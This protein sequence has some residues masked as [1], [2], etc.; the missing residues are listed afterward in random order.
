MG[1]LP[2]ESFEPNGKPGNMP[3]P[4]A[5]S[6]VLKR[7]AAT[8]TNDIT[9]GDVQSA[10]ADRSFA[11]LVMFFALVNMLPLPIGTSLILGV[12][13]LLLSVQMVMGRSAPWLPRFVRERSIAPETFRRMESRLNPWIEWMEKFIKPRK[14]PFDRIMGERVLGV[15]IVFLAILLIIPIPMGNWPPAFAIFLVALALWERDGYML[16]VALAASVTATVLFTISATVIV[17][18]SKGAAAYIPFL[19]G[20]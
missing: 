19:H 17:M 4:H 6:D 12:P 16:V 11:A 2:F 14:W 15:L 13:L 7:L 18:V 1:Q 10:L 9:I 20:T 8:A 3:P 5:F